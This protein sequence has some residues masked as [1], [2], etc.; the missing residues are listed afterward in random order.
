[1]ERGTF[2]SGE[3][4]S[5]E[6]L[7]LQD[8]FGETPRNSSIESR[9]RD[10]RKCLP[11][12]RKVRREECY[13]SEQCLRDSNAIFRFSGRY[14]RINRSEKRGVLSLGNIRTLSRLQSAS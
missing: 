1:M 6:D 4:S 9:K 5:V 13:G 7:P 11:E 3:A 14:S 12:E 10:Q 8:M 2:L